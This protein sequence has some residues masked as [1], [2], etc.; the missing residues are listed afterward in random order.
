M[1]IH[2]AYFDI[3]KIY[4]ENF[5]SGADQDG[6]A[7]SV[8]SVNRILVVNTVTVMG[9]LGS[10]SVIRTGVGYSVIKV[11]LLL[12]HAANFVPP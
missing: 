4:T 1:V 7:I 9:P 3:L 2:L 10:A 12:I 11:R 6:E 8:I 5:I